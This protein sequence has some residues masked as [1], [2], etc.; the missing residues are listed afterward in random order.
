ML[1]RFAMLVLFAFCPTAV[2]AQATKGAAMPEGTKV[3]KDVAYGDHTRNKLDVFAP[4]SE[5][6]LPL[7]IWIHGGGWEAGSK[8]NNPVVALLDKGYA[9][10]GINYRYSTQAPFPAQLHD[11]QAAIRFLRDNAKKY[12]ID[13]DRIGVWGA[14]AGGHLVSLLGTAGDV[15]ELDGDPNSKTSVKVQAVLNWFGPTD[16]TK[17][18][19]PGAET[20]GVFVKL[21]GGSLKDKADLA[22]SANPIT[23]VTKNDAPFLI[24]HGD[25]DPLVPLSQSEILHAALKKAGV[26]TELVVF[27]K[28]GHGDGPFRAAVMKDDHRKVMLDFF[29][30][31]LKP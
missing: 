11:C 14:S 18:V 22:K 21:L 24:V 29:G 8:E 5:K 7:V 2:S 1:R 30:K 17:M 4:P 12:N 31:H 27:P 6:P 16:L 15:P 28:A 20:P 19:K 13:G 3:S 23:H 26:A 9:V 10:A 25:N